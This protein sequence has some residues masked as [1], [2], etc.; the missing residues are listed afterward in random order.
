[1]RNLVLGILSLVVFCLLFGYG[2]LLLDFVPFPHFFAVGLFGVMLLSAL[3]VFGIIGI[4][5][6]LGNADSD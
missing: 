4:V 2:P 6:G 3:F 5:S 1:M